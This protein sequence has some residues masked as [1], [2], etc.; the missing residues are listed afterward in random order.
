MECSLGIDIGGSHISGGIVNRTSGEVLLHSYKEQPIDPLGPRQVILDTWTAFIQ[1]LLKFQLDSPIKTIGFA[2]PGPFDYENGIASFDGVPKYNSLKGVNIREYL[3]NNLPDGQ[4]LNIHF[5]NDATAFAVGEYLSGAAQ[6]LDRVWV[7][8]LGTGFGST[9]LIN[10]I[11]TFSGPGMPDGG[12]L[13]YQP[14][15]Q[16]IAEESLSTRWFENT[17]HK[18][19]GKTIK[20]VKPLADLYTQ[21]NAEAKQLFNDFA[22]NLAAFLA[23]WLKSTEAHGVVI[24]GGITKAWEYF[25][26]QT[27]AHL[28]SAG[29]DIILR[30]GALGKYAPIIGAVS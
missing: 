13:Y 29:L 11:P 14:F 23:P 17:W 30:K 18:R 8:T 20:G 12:Y 22:E 19:T 24:G 27:E 21:G 4:N 1:S 3:K 15:K 16:G 25:A 2:M 7:L 9:F 5:K 6:N 10:G 28:R 26:P